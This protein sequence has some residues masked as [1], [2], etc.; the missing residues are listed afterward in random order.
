M[1]RRIHNVERAAGALEA[2]VRHGAPPSAEGSDIARAAAA[3]VERAAAILRATPDSPTRAEVY[4]EPQDLPPGPLGELLL[5][6]R[7][8]ANATA[9]LAAELA[10]RIGQQ[11]PGLIGGRG[12]IGVPPPRE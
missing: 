12:R 1:F 10:A 9:V 3:D 11:R 7:T 2:V 4:R 8:E 5:V 6:T